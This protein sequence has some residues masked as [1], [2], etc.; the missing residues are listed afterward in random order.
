MKEHIGTHR[1]IVFT[2]IAIIALA[3][4]VIP[5]SSIIVPVSGQGDDLIFDILGG[6][7]V[8]IARNLA[9]FKDSSFNTLTQTNGQSIEDVSDVDS[10][11]T[12][13]EHTLMA[14]SLGVFKSAIHN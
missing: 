5:F 13:R 8:N 12:V 3:S 14:S 6:D 7:S 4:Y 2:A 1:N 11:R 10:I 9:S